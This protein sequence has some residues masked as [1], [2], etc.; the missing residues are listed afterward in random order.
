MINNLPQLSNR[1]SVSEI[2]TGLIL[3]GK[4][5]ITGYNPEYF[6]GEYEKVIRDI[7]AGVP[8]EELLAQDKSTIIQTAFIAAKS[9]NGIGDVDWRDVIYRAYKRETIIDELHNAIKYAQRQDDAHLGDTLRRL[10]ATFSS[11]QRLRSITADVIE[12]TYSP[13]MESGSIAWDMHIGGFPTVGVVIIAAKWYVGK[14][15]AAIRLM[16]SF[17]R[18]YPER[19][20]LFVTLEDMNEGWKDRAL[21]ILGE[22]SKDFWRR[23]R[24]M[25]FARGVNEIIE[26]AARHENVGM[27]ITDYIDYLATDKDLASYEEIYKSM[28]LGAKS[29]AVNSKFRAMPILLLSQFGKSLYKGGVPTADV[30]PYTGQQYAYQ[31]VTLYR[32]E[33]DY[34]SDNPENVYM[35]PPVDH[36]GYIAVWKVKNGCRPHLDE[37]PGAIQV[38]W[39]SRYG[40][41]FDNEGRWFPLIPES[42]KK[43]KK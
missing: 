43:K 14:T 38:P 12:E 27:I 32:P 35:L 23:V 42:N 6:A 21:T 7:R 39:S 10:N 29:L 5:S 25:E 26:E 24:V 17:L 3:L 30:I 1:L 8:I 36:Y 11:S 34:F 40:Y 16:D 41:D 33:G 4:E 2:V 28:S 31:I 20:V 19:E 13:F 37:F 15:T 18:R 9:V 22:R